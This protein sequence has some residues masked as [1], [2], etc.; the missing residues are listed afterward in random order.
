MIPIKPNKKN[1]VDIGPL[2]LI[3]IKDILGSLYYVY[4]NNISVTVNRLERN[5]S[6][7]ASIV[8]INKE[9]GT[10]TLKTEEG[11]YFKPGEKIKISFIINSIRY[12]FNSSVASVD[13]ELEILFN[14][15]KVI[16]YDEH[17]ILPRIN[18]PEA[19][20]NGLELVTGIFSG[21]RIK[22]KVEDISLG[23]LGFTPNNIESLR[24]SN[25]IN[26]KD[27]KIKTG[28]KFRKLRFEIDEDVLDIPVEICHTPN[29]ERNT[30]G[31]KF[32]LSK[33]KHCNKLKEFIQSWTPHKK[34]INFASYYD[35]IKSKID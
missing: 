4:L 23:G 30:F 34:V 35:E 25:E 3:N 15:P 26:L 18:L 7:S 17:R 28:D 21:V 5:Y 12:G 27:T 1:S 10:T 29:E 24:D 31:I 11:V 16:H 32:D 9:L 19:M 2:D 14:M 33:G 8:N 22:G 6:V 13:K 20:S